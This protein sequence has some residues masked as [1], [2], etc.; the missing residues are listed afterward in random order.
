MISTNS[1]N[2]IELKIG[3]VADVVA[4]GTPKSGNADNFEEPGTGIAWLTPAD[5]SGYTE[6]YISFGARDL[7][8]QGYDSS[9]AK[10][11]P[12][13]SL[14]FSSRAPIGYVAIAQNEISTNQGFKNFVFPYGVDSDYAYY[15]LRSIK[16]VAESMGTGTTF[17]EISGAIAKTLPFVLPPLAEQKIIADKLDVL[18]TQVETTKKRLELIPG[19][20]KRFRQSI[21]T[22]AVSGKLTEGWRERN[23]LTPPKVTWTSALEIANA[24]EIPQQWI[25]VS[26]GSVSNRVSVGHV[27]KTSEFYT[28]EKDGIPFL[29][30][31]NVRPGKISTEGLAYITPEFHRSLKK[32]QLKPGDLL[33]VRVGANRGDACILPSMF[34]EVNC[35]NIVFARPMN[36]LS[37][38]LNI[39]F[40][41]P[42]SQ[43]L[44]L[45]E[46]VGGAQG[47]INTKSI[48]GTFLAL[49]PIEEQAEIVHRVEELF[50]YAE[51]IEQN[52]ST[53]LAQVNGLTQSILAKAF[54][55]E[56]TA[57][58]RSANS[59][60]ISG[61]NSTE[62]LL[63]K[64]KT[65]REAIKRRSKP[66]KNDVKKKTGSHMSKQIIKV[67]EAL[68]QA[69]EPLSGQHL[70]AAAGYPSDSSTDQLEQFFLDIRDALYIEKS[71]IKLER[72]D[73]GQ[74][75]FAL[76]EIV[77]KSKA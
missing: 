45:G 67:V 36:G 15:Y 46:T 53:A 1:G 34:S 29:R 13:G 18:L 42:I 64:I 3:D 11:L 43:S 32:S 8:R 51:T 4:G 54:R 21:L 55:G 65:E 77:E 19:I 28:N 57:D 61:D 50:T 58:W 17:K 63:K 59:E 26:L 9:S 70:L 22:A 6:K 40:Q 12:K 10:I 74:D 60:L 68:K 20:L 37:K 33:V 75:W 35:A 30:S 47:V 62:N 38:Y 7:S 16:G 24:F 27:G 49:P 14:L 76:T 41:S 2:W 23:S 72:D 31:Q 5:L 56:L 69:G 73:D 52:F 48:E 71:I 25:G 44:L 66:K 39:Y